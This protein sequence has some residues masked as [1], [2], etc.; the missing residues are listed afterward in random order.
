MGI[1]RGTGAS[2]HKFSKESMKLNW[3]FQRGRG[4]HT[5]KPSVEGGMYFFPESGYIYR[6]NI[7]DFKRES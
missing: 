4:V 1:P 2:K 5:E 7:M 6:F 3:N